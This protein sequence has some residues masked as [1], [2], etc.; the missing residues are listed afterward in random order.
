[1]EVT[2]AT[3]SPPTHPTLGAARQLAG[4]VSERTPRTVVCTP[5][6]R[7]SQRKRARSLRCHP[8]GCIR[9]AHSF[10]TPRAPRVVAR[11][12]EGRGPRAATPLR[13][14]ARTRSLPLAPVAPGGG[15]H[16]PCATSGNTGGLGEGALRGHSPTHT[17]SRTLAL[18]TFARVRPPLFRTRESMASR[19]LRTLSCGCGYTSRA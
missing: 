9:R 6:H 3:E 5:V 4:A 2:L 7:V 12:G 16:P 14:R 17:R 15:I 19:V 10:N 13:I 18:R 1:M 8:L 11:A